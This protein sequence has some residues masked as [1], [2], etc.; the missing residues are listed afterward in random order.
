V[1]QKEEEEEKNAV[2]SG[3]LVLFQHKPL[4]AK[5]AQYNKYRDAMISYKKIQR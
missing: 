2:N 1:K 4:G 5:K 3:H